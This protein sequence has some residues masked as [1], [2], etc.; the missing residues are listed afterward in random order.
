[1]ADI[2]I[3]YAREDQAT[4]EKLAQALIAHG[5]S[6]WWDRHIPAGSRFDEV[7]AEQLSSASCVLVLWSK[8]G[9][10]SQWVMEEAETAWTSGVLVPI[11][12][13]AVQLPMGFRRIHAAD[14]IGWNDTASHTGFEQLLIDVASIIDRHR[15]QHAAASLQPF[16]ESALERVPPEP[17]KSETMRTV[18]W[19][20]DALGV[21]GAEDVAAAND[22]ALRRDSPAFPSFAVETA[23]DAAAI[24][25]IENDL[26][27]FI[28]PVAKVV[29]SR[30]MQKA[31]DLESLCAAVAR[32]I[33]FDADR[34]YFLTRVN[35]LG[36]SRPLSIVNGGK[37]AK[38]SSGS[39]REYPD[40]LAVDANL[41]E[42][43]QSLAYHIG[44]IT[45]VILKRA[46]AQNLAREDFCEYLATH[47][48]GEDERRQFLATVTR[49]I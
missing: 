23:W 34:R 28:G 27:H 1:M 6:V 44:P 31:T 36:P 35:I 21:R 24:E 10:Q 46:M 47:I 29:V 30:A 7:I 33:P 3:S 20:E 49:W 4:A 41:D 25:T 26:T 32:S 37:M 40:P 9:I 14:L 12:I 38:P 13:E 18:A 48:D 15:R 22:G 16:P 43:E 5:W 17:E 42:I 19:T 45:K 2:F 8:N 11:M 39:A